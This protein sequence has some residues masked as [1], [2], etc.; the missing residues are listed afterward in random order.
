MELYN[1][2]RRG[3]TVSNSSETSLPKINYTKKFRRPIPLPSGWTAVTGKSTHR[4]KLGHLF[5]SFLASSVCEVA[6]VAPRQV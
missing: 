2:A 5:G 1:D 4:A 6:G 3:R